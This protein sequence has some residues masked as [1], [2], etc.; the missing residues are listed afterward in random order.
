[1]TF[2]LGVGLVL[3]AWSGGT[4]SSFFGLA[5]WLRK[6]TEA[7][8]TADAI[9]AGFFADAPKAPPLKLRGPLLWFLLGW[10]TVL[11]IGLGLIAVAI[12]PTH[13]I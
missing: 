8:V 12:F 10:C 11:L 1:M 4:L 5:T 3:V 6:K 13:S 9:R 2:A 7:F